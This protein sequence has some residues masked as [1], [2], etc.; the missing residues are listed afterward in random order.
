[1]YSVNANFVVEDKSN[2]IFAVDIHHLIMGKQILI[3]ILK[4]FSLHL[5][6]TAT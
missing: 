5:V 3:N 2:G 1:M 6:Y 4:Y